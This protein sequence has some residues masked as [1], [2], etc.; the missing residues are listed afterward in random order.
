[1]RPALLALAAWLGLAASAGAQTL[2]WYDAVFP[3]HSFDFGTVA[4]GSKIK[5]AFRLV[6]TTD[7]TLHIVNWT[8]KCGCTDVQVGAKEIPPGTQTFVEATIDTT[9]FQGFKSSGLTLTFDRPTYAQKDLTVTCFIRGD[10]LLSPG[11]VEFGT[12]NRTSGATQLL[13]LSYVGGQT[14][15]G[16]LKLTTLTDHVAARLEEIPGTRTA[17]SVQYR[18]TAALKPTAPVGYFKDEIVLETNDPTSPRI[19][20]SV[21]ANVES[22]VVVAPHVLALSTVRP[23]QVISRDVLVRAREPFVVSDVASTADSLSGTAAD[24]TARPLQKVRV[25]LK[26]PAQPGPFHATLAIKTSLADEPPAE[27][28]VFATVAP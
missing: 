18:L 22:N 5:H 1:M 6:N 13:T 23:G 11:A 19:P 15:W 7:Q 25:T 17:G 9:K 24:Q 16:V 3:E 20:V 28:S 12:V 2:N 10:V 14:N 26:A 8:T 27:L 21:S 4:R